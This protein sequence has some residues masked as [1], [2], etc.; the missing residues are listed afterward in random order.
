M[1][2]RQFL[3]GVIATGAAALGAGTIVTTAANASTGAGAVPSG[4]AEAWLLSTGRLAA[5]T[6]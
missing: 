3:Y 1:E 2:R 5:A 6:H 4:S